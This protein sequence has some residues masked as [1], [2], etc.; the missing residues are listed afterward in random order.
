M[1]GLENKY[2][3]PLT[4]DQ[5]Q[6]MMQLMLLDEEPE[7]MREEIVG[8]DIAAAVLSKRIEA[9][10]LPVKLSAKALMYVVILCAGNPGRAVVTL[11]DILDAEL[12]EVTMDDLVRIYPW[13]H[14]NEERLGVVIDEHKQRVH[15]WSHIY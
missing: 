14:Y 2:A 11:I 4:G 9:F 10:D 8:K 1:N 7:G 6:L 5:S 12:N 15:K 13:G 3:Q